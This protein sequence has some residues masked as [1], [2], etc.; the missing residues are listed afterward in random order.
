VSEFL[1]YFSNIAESKLYTEMQPL[2]FPP[3]E[4]RINSKDG[5]QQ[6]FD[7]VRKRF[8]ALTPEEWV[9]QHV[10]HH[11][12]DEKAVPLSLIGVEVRLKLNSLV[13]FA[14]VVVYSRSGK[15]LML[16]ECKA[17]GVAV[18]QQVFEQA[19]NYDMV[20]HVN[21]MLITNGLSHYCCKFNLAEH[22]YSFLPDIP[23]YKEMI[24]A[25]EI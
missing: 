24:S 17:P 13:K 18:T 1:S 23:V 10:L 11:L 12:A 4:F 14:D 15:P 6:I 2:N 3:C 7:I 22:T 9:R 25:L 8:V 19:A 5:K 20:F 16:V 21:F